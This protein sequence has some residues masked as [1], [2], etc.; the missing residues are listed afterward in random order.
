MLLLDPGNTGGF[1]DLLFKEAA[2]YAE[3]TCGKRKVLDL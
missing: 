3:I 1:V 2:R